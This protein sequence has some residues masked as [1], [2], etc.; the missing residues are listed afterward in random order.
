LVSDEDGLGFADQLRAD[1]GGG[2]GGSTPA[3]T[4]SVPAVLAQRALC[5]GGNGAADA[6]IKAT[7][8]LTA[9]QCAGSDLLWQSQS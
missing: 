3:R 1:R 2:V 7:G 9:Q 8:A 4:A 6:K 5:N